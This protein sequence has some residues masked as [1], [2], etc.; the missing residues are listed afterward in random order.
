MSKKE[1]KSALELHRIYIDDVNA[2]ME[3]QF[4]SIV[5]KIADSV[6]YVCNGLEQHMGGNEYFTLTS[7][8]NDDKVEIRPSNSLDVGLILKEKSIHYFDYQGIFIRDNAYRYGTNFL[9][10]VRDNSITICRKP[11]N[12]END[13]TRI[14]EV[15]NGEYIENTITDME[16]TLWVLCAV[17]DAFASI[18]YGANETPI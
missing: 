17:I 10:L 8:F 15:K 18:T 3:Q 12:P 4:V 16:G 2:Y 11:E 7:D 5:S 13:E 9:V 1:K 6:K 14:V